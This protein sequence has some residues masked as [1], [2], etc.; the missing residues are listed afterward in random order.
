MKKILFIKGAM[1]NMLFVFCAICTSIFY[2]S[3]NKDSVI[4]VPSMSTSTNCYTRSTTNNISIL[5]TECNVCLK[6]NQFTIL[7][8]KHALRKGIHGIDYDMIKQSVDQAN[9][10]LLKIVTELEEQGYEVEV[11]DISADSKVDIASHV[12]TLTSG[13]ERAM[14][15]GVIETNDGSPKEETHFAPTRMTAVRGNCIA[16]TALCPLHT[17]T[18]TYAGGNAKVGTA[19]GPG[20]KTITVPLSMS[21]TNFGIKYCTSDSNG[22]KCV[23]E[24]VTN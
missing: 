1:S 20:N 24:G 22:G 7:S 23:W 6:N 16:H 18:T 14:P 12:E 8:R 11:Y 19:F 17:L 21:N 9:V 5:I 15:K 2:V 10:L 4:D 13:E 3:C